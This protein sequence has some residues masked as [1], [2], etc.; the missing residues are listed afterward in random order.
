MPELTIEPELAHVRTFIVRTI[1]F[2]GSEAD[3]VTVALITPA[4][5]LQ[6]LD[7]VSLEWRRVK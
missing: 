4:E 3:F 6:I 5:I 1:N 2:D 7:D